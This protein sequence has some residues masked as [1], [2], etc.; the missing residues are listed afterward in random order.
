MIG[1]AVFMIGFGLAILIFPNLLETLIAYF[2]LF[3]G[4]SVLITSW[5]SNRKNMRFGDYEIKIE[6]TKRK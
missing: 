3:T 4:A 6:N 1:L 2:F 5:I